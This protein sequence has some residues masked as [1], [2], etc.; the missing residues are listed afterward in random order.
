[1]HPHSRPQ[2]RLA[3][4]TAEPEYEVLV[5]RFQGLRGPSGSGDENDASAILV[6]SFGTTWRANLHFK[7]IL[8]IQS[9]FFI[10][11]SFQFKDSK[12]L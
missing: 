1:M 5:L 12:D 2:S 11:I 7:E 4:L 10:I 8:E 3:L 6:F 9:N